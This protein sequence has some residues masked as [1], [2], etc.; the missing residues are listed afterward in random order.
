VRLDHLL[1]KEPLEDIRSF[2]LRG[3]LTIQLIGTR[4]EEGGAAGNGGYDLRGCRGASVLGTLCSFEGCGLR[5]FHS[6]RWGRVDP[7]RTTRQPT[8]TVTLSA[9][10]PARIRP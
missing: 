4:S 10:A 8:N 7:G 5:A 9:K 1:S 2:Q 3:S 6:S